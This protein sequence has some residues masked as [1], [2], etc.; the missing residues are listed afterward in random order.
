MTQQIGAQRYV[1]ILGTQQ[2]K[3][4]LA[5]EFGSEADLLKTLRAKRLQEELHREKF[6][7]QRVNKR[8]FEDCQRAEQAELARKQQYRMIADENRR[9]AE[10]KRMNATAER[11]NTNVK[12]QVAIRSNYQSV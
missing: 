4:K 6:E 3:R 9:L 5:K 10:M 12:E 11:V 2:Q 8:Y 1:Q 7:T